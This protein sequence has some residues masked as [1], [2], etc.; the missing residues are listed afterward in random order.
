MTVDVFIP[1]QMPPGQV[2]VMALVQVF[3]GV[4]QL[5]GPGPSTAD[6]VVRLDPA[7]LH[8]QTEHGP[9]QGLAYRRG[10]CPE[11]LVSP[12]VE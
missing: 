11:L 6:Q 12:G 8:R 9:S 4:R 5:P 7:V 2:T 3:V 1:Q 10:L